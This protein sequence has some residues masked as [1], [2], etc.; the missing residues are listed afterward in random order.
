MKLFAKLWNDDAGIVVLE[1]LLLAGQGFTWE[2]LWRLDL[3]TLGA[4]FLPDEEKET[5]RREWAAFAT[6]T[7]LVKARDA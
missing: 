1:Y 5:C 6:K 7:L 4:S 2:E 3:N